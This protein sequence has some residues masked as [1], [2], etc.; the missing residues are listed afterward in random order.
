MIER[1]TRSADETRALGRA[2]GAAA[3]PGAVLLLRGD[4]GS[5][6]TTFAQGVGEGLGVNEVTSPTF[7]LVAEHRG[8]LPLFHVDL[9]R[10]GDVEDLS[11]LGLDDVLGRV[12][13]VVVEWPE[14][15]LG[16]WPEERLDIDLSGEDDERT[17]TFRAT[18]PRHAA[19]LRRAG[20]AP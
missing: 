9:Y 13:V 8:R 19:L 1:K 6:K 11:A 3:E 10:L 7:I 18:G 12:G 2:L 15:Y 5:G 4:L 16:A 17:I 14:R 20:I